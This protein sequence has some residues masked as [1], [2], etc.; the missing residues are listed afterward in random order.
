MKPGLEGLNASY[1]PVKSLDGVEMY[2][3]GEER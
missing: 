3:E 2:Q 1:A